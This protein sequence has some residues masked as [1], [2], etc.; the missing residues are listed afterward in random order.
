[1]QIAT[2]SR[3]GRRATAV[4]RC[5]RSRSASGSA[6]PSRAAPPAPRRSRRRTH[7]PTRRTRPRRSHRET[8]RAA[9]RRSR[10][11]RRADA[12]DPDPA[13]T[14][15]N[16]QGAGAAPP[17]AR[18]GHHRH[19]RVPP[20]RATESCWP[21]VRVCASSIAV[22]AAFTRAS[23]SGNSTSSLVAK[24][25]KNVRRADVGRCGDVG[26][27]GAS[28]PRRSNSSAAASINAAGCAHACAPAVTTC[29][30]PYPETV[31]FLHSL[32]FCIYC[33]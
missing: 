4:A 20:T 17:S 5:S 8:R 24:Y 10:S 23:A 13:V 12:V 30:A 28:Y 18:P 1:M 29:A 31:N 26:D 22:S 25:P 14:G 11:A 33:N 16:A 27:R 21:L 15:L 7:R 9:G 6:W 2:A 3:P 32:H 19:R